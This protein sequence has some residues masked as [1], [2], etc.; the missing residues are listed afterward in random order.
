MNE[1]HLE[2]V[3]EGSQD[4]PVGLEVH[5]ANGDCA[6]AQE[7][8]LSLDVELLQEEQAVAG[9]VHDTPHSTSC[10]TH[11]YTHIVIHNIKIRF[12]RGYVVQTWVKI[13]FASF[14]IVWGGVCTS[15]TIQIGSIVPGKLNK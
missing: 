6:V 7:A 5:V 2:V 8:K 12:R 14:Q 15:G 9:H 3:R 11:K 1:D 13:V 4:S 10:H